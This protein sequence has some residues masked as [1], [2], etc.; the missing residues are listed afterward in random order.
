[1]SDKKEILLDSGT[2]EMEALIFRL[3]GQEYGVNVAKIHELITPPVTRSLPGSSP[4]VTGVFRLRDENIALVDLAFHLNPEE[5]R[6]EN[7]NTVIIT[8]FNGK[9]TAFLV[10]SADHIERV[11]WDQIVPPADG[12]VNEGGI[13]GI[14]QLT[15]RIVPMLDFEAIQG[16]IVGRPWGELESEKVAHADMRGA[17]NIYVVDDSSVVRKSLFAIL[18]DAGV[19]QITMFNNGEEAWRSICQA[20]TAGLLPSKIRTD[21]VDSDHR[22]SVAER[23]TGK[24]Q[25]RVTATCARSPCSGD[26]R[27]ADPLAAQ[28]ARKTLDSHV[29]HC[30][31]A[32][33][34][35]KPILT[36]KG[37]GNL[38]PIEHRL[39]ARIS[40]LE[41]A[42]LD[43]KKLL[44]VVEFG[45]VIGS[46]S[47]FAVR[48]HNRQQFGIKRR[49][50]LD[51]YAETRPGRTAPRN[52][53]SVAVVMTDTHAVA[54]WRYR[55]TRT[56]HTHVGGSRAQSAKRTRSAIATHRKLRK[57]LLTT[58][59]R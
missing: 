59:R 53:D 6:L 20:S 9:K 25:D 14:L 5:G 38:G 44:G 7:G 48:T 52:G 43:R 24:R 51:V 41:H 40:R 28:A 18:E 19:G 33:P 30:H 2:N 47:T 42:L 11:S 23:R 17:F 27:K 10:D 12:L 50:R 22:R 46:G 57:P 45:D 37:H 1:V 31:V 29:R 26:R 21:Q 16:Q 36:L 35:D 39:H 54:L 4:S 56:P 3:K 34:R 8:A 13:T 49:I 55:L 58:S 32:Q 15:D